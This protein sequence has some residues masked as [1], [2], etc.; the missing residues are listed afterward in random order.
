MPEDL[1]VGGLIFGD[2]GTLFKASETGTN[3]RDDIK[4]KVQLALVFH[5]SLHLD[6]LRFIY[7]RHSL[8]ESFDKVETFRFSFG[9]TY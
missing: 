1:G 9:T 3:V 6:L 5:G 4:F 7:Q 2:I 8:K